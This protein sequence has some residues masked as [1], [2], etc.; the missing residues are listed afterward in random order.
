MA[1]LASKIIPYSYR[2]NDDASVRRRLYKEFSHAENGHPV[3]FSSPPSNIRIEESYW[4][5]ERCVGVEG[6]GRRGG[7][8]VA[9]SL[10]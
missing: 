6:K 4:V 2:W 1:Y 5:N 9:D 10:L 8:V 7:I 3:G